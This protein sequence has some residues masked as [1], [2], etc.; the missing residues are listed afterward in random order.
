MPTNSPLTNSLSGEVRP[1]LACAGRS[2]RILALLQFRNEMRYLPDYFQNVTP[3]VDGIIALDDDS[4]DGSGEYVLQQSS[5]LQV[6]RLAPAGPHVWNEPRNR[7]SLIEAAWDH[8]PGWLLAMDADERLERDF[9][10]R[11]QVEIERAERKGFLA[12]RVTLLELWGR[13]D[14]YRAD[15]IWGQKRPPRFFKARRDHVFDARPEHGMWPPL[16]SRTNGEYPKADLIIYHLRMVNL[17][18]RL[19]RQARY[20]KLDPHNQSQTIGYDYLTD[21]Q[22]LVLKKLTADRGYEPLRSP[23]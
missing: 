14:T 20:R 19:A 4:T 18:D 3:Q 1:E 17:A 21:T 10:Q 11:A 9:R 22:G 12:Y 15:G 6:I 7:R 13:P 23:D 8:R 16:N 5:V 2:S